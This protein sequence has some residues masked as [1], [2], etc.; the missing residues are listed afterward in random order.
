[1]AVLETHI[2]HKYRSAGFDAANTD[3][4]E[5]D[6]MDCTE[7]DQ[8]QGWL[9]SYYLDRA[10]CRGI[11]FEAEVPYLAK[12][13]DTCK[14][15]QRFLTGLKGFATVPGTERAHAQAV[16]QVPVAIA[17]AAN[18]AFQFYKGGAFPCASDSTGINHAVMLVGYND[19][20]T[21]KSGDTWKVWYVKNSW[22][23]TWGSGGYVMMRKDC[24]EFFLAGVVFV[25]G[26]GVFPGGVSLAF[27]TSV[28]SAC[29]VLLTP[30]PPPSRRA[31]LCPPPSSTK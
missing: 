20:V 4:S 30:R 11:A 29:L 3:L 24:G 28:L 7:G 31:T 22:A 19:G 26:G 17:V 16:N 14:P 2:A 9:P 8:C 5:Q 15:L 27:S 13:A 18:T 25:A 21:M 1:M 6:P 12:D 23:K 10:V